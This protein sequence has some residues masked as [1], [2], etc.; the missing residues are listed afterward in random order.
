MNRDDNFQPDQ[1]AAANLVMKENADLLMGTISSG[2]A[3]R[4]IRP[5]K[6]GGDPIPL[7]LCK[8]REDHGGKRHRYVIE[9][10]EG[11]AIETSAIGKLEMRT[12]DHQLLLPCF[13]E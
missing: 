1:A 10:L 11:M 9:A 4:H 3:P 5:R 6:E 7:Y 2:S 8:E 13:T 12:C